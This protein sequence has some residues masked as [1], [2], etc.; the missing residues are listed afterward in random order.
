MAFWIKQIEMMALPEVKKLGDDV[1]CVD[2]F[3]HDGNLC[4]DQLPATSNDLSHR[5]VLVRGTIN[6]NC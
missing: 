5:Q 1:Y 6:D 4:P 3:G 2:P